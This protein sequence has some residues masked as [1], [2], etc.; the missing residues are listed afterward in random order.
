MPALLL[1]GISTASG[2]LGVEYLQPSLDIS[3]KLH[4][5]SSCISYSGSI[6]VS[7]RTCQRSTQMV[8]SG[9]TV[10]D[11]GSLASHS[12]QHVGRHS[13]A[14]PHHKRS[15]HGCL[16][17]P[18]AQGSAISAF[19]PL[20]A[21]QCVLHRRVLFLSLSGSGGDNSHL[22]QRSTSSVGRNGQVGVLNRVYQTMLSLLLNKLII[23]YIYFRLAWPGIPLVYIILLFLPFWNLIVLTRLLI[24]LSFQN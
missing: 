22:C 1:I 11:R 17:R 19:N 6:Q 16:S 18:G 15:L 2:G 7:G 23:C 14:V 3:G 10:L 24:I 9:G 21:Q 13:S 5:S 8:D 4:V 20:A 12:S